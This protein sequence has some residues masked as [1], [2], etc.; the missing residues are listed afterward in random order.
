[1]L[2]VL[3]WTAP[4]AAMRESFIAALLSY[5]ALV[6]ALMGG[7]HWALA[8][9]PYGYA[10]VAAEWA[11]GFACLLIAWACLNLPAY[12]SLTIMTAAFFLLALRDVVMAETAGIPLWFARMLSYVTATAIVT[13]VFALLSILT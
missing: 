8:T 12:L 13:A 9:G 11:V 10:R 2:L 1:V 3:I 7:A 5:E 6:L 4:S